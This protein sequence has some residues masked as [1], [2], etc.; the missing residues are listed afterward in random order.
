MGHCRLEL[1]SRSELD[2][3]LSFF[4]LLCH[5]LQ[6]LAEIS[7]FPSQAKTDDRDEKRG[8]ERNKTSNYIICFSSTSNF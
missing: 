5:T 7:I 4:S 6:L 3:A 1:C 8:R 2:Y